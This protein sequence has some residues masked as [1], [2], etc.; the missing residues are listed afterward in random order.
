VVY[1]IPAQA[2]SLPGGA[3]AVSSS[4]LP[5]GAHQARSDFGA[6]AYGGPCPPQ[7]DR[8][9]HYVVTVSALDVATLSVPDN[10]TP[11]VVGF[12]IHSHLVGTARLTAL[13]GR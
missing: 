8:P 12:T 4:L 2:T 1:D 3:G 13:Y 10:P 5:A 11:A 9:H 7:G 6:A